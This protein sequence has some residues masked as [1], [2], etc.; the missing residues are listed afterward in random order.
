MKNTIKKLYAVAVRSST[1]A[2]II[3]II[4]VIGFSVMSCTTVPPGPVATYKQQGAPGVAGW[5]GDGD[6][7]PSGYSEIKLNDNTYRVSFSGNRY[8]ERNNAYVFFLTRSA[9]IAKANNCSYFLVLNVEDQSTAGSLTTGGYSVPYSAG[10]FSTTINVPQTTQ[11]F[12]VPS[13]TGEVQIYNARRGVENEFEANAIFE[14]GM[15]LKESALRY[16]EDRA[17]A[18]RRFL[19]ETVGWSVGGTAVF[20]LIILLPLGLL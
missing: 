8:T 19:L 14:Q 3:A 2:G 12:V 13:F 9:E 1:I 4:T 11:T 5:F 18:N 15:E 17:D 20:L 6:T 10:G 7:T 16:N